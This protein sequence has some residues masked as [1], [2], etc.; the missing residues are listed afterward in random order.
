MKFIMVCA[1]TKEGVIGIRNE[2][3]WKCSTDL[4]LF[5]ELTTEGIVLMGQRTFDSIG[6]PLPNRLNLVITRLYPT[7]KDLPRSK[8]IL[9]TSVAYI[10]INDVGNDVLSIIKHVEKITAQYNQD[11]FVIGGR[12][13]YDLFAEFCSKYVIS[14]MEV[15]IPESE[16]NVL[17][18]DKTM[19]IL[20]DNG[21]TS[22]ARTQNLKGNNIVVTEYR[23]NKSE[24]SFLHISSEINSLDKGEVNHVT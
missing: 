4:K 13:I 19:K 9:G 16:D 8:K 14:L 11:V 2:L 7:T 18:T 23:D 21:I 20:R 22:L 6:R 12:Y 17:L 15:Y 10:N 5:R 3:P 1:A 24:P